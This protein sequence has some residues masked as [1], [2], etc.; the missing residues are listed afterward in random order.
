MEFPIVGHSSQ[1]S[2][3]RWGDT[4]RWC[5]CHAAHH[6][7]ELWASHSSVPGWNWLQANQN[8]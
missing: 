2:S 6:G 8:A 3:E 1:G 4:A 5:V 7:H